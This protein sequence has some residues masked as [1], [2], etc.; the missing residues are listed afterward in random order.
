[1]YYEFSGDLFAPFTK[2]AKSYKLTLRSLDSG[3]PILIFF[4]NM[5]SDN[6]AKENTHTVDE[7]AKL[8]MHL[9][10]SIYMYYNIKEMEM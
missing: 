5:T 2:I 7:H 4:L 10:K 3:N 1:M 9:R 6:F 8:K